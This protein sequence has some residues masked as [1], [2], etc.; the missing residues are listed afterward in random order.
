MAPIFSPFW[1]FLVLQILFYFT[2]NLS[3]NI[4]TY[5]FVPF[6]SS[7]PL[8]SLIY[9]YGKMYVQ[10]VQKHWRRFHILGFFV[11]LWNKWK[12]FWKTKQTA[13]QNVCN[14]FEYTQLDWLQRQESSFCFHCLR[15]SVCLFTSI[16]VYNNNNNWMC[17]GYSKKIL[18]VK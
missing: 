7:F 14:K 3:L 11:L 2:L 15:V 18:H 9:D 1:C 4:S 13:E 12:Y 5:K 17:F 8:N 16:W 10:T 6:F